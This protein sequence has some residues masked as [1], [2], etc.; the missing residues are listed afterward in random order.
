MKYNYP[1][2]ANI[3]TRNQNELIVGEKY[4]YKESSAIGECI[5][6]E[7]KSDDKYYRWK[8]CWTEYSPYEGSCSGEFE[9][10]ELKNSNFCY[11]GMWQILPRGSYLIKNRDLNEKTK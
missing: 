10:C 4:D 8:F 7:D 3:S 5:F 1:D 2:S 11:S 6:V 9:C